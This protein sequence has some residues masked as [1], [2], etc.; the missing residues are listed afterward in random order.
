MPKGDST[1][2]F[3]HASGPEPHRARTKEILQEHPEIRT[4]IS[5]NPASFSFIFLLVILQTTLAWLLADAAWWMVFVAAYLIGAF[6]DHG[7]FVLIH[8][9]AHNLIFKKKSLNIWAGMIANLPQ[10]FPSSVSFQRYHLK[11]HTFQGI[12]ELDADLPGK[13]EARL[14]GSSFFGKA[15]WL[16]LFPFFQISRTFRLREIPLMDRWILLNWVL[17]FIFN[18][19][20]FFIMGPKALIYLAA[21]LFF[22]VGLHPLGARW[23]QEHFL[24]SGPQETHSYYGPL[25][26]IAFNVGYHNE[27]HEFPSVPWNKLPKI[28]SIAKNYYVSLHAHN[29]WTKL[30]FRFL[31]DKNLSLYSRV[32]RENRGGISVKENL[33]PDQESEIKIH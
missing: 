28:K 9:S 32:L 2:D 31:F 21:S 10:F 18:V 30:L 24:T 11:H 23:I 13:L 12:H 5:R 17:M 22:S 3:R 29:S 33:V 6:L 16:L 1:I 8:E 25:N 7:L 15:I 27:H 20:V 26:K 4:L 14:I 19:A